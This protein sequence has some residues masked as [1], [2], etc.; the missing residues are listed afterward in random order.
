M[1][2]SEAMEFFQVKQSVMSAEGMII[3]C[4]GVH[5]TYILTISQIV[6]DDADF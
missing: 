4:S 1:G 6:A 2:S 5:T 3:Y